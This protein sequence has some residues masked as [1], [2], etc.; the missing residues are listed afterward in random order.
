MFVC[1][2]ITP[3]LGFK[4]S[5]SVYSQERAH[6]A[7]QHPCPE[8][9]CNLTFSDSSMTVGQAQ[10][11]EALGRDSS[12]SFLTHCGTQGDIAWINS[13]S[14]IQLIAII[15]L[16]MYPLAITFSLFKLFAFSI[17]VKTF[18]PCL[19]TN[20]TLFIAI[21]LVAV[22]S[23]INMNICNFISF[24]SAVTVNDHIPN[25]GV[26]FCVCFCWT[27]WMW[28]SRASL[29]IQWEWR[30]VK[31]TQTSYPLTISLLSTSRR[32]VHCI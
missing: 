10:R 31:L 11:G 27:G 29:C 9:L 13:T 28:T 6:Q 4:K 1:N 15:S 3:V 7:S 23:R 14:K 8:P 19:Y 32:P 17:A 24:S 22:A 16:I 2:S 20:T 18:L 30:A 25:T 21:S 26:L 5:L 12:T